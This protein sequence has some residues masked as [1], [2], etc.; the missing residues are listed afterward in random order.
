MACGLE[1]TGKIILRSQTW[2]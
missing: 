2:I 1:E